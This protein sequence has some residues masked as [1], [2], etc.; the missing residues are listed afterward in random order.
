MAK[1]KKALLKDAKELYG[2][3]LDASLTLKKIKAEIANLAAAKNE[4]VLKEEVPQA[5]NETVDVTVTAK[6]ITEEVAEDEGPGEEVT[7]TEVTQSLPR[8]TQEEAAPAVAPQPQGTPPEMSRGEKYMQQ[9]INIY[10]K[11]KRE[12]NPAGDVNEAKRMINAFVSIMNNCKASNELKVTQMVFNMFIQH[13]N[14]MLAPKTALAGIGELRKTSS[15]TAHLLEVFYTVMMHGVEKRLRQT[16][17]HLD[18]K[19]ARAILKD[20]PILEFVAGI[21]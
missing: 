15:V 20:H 18:M 11:L 17:T 5:E 21:E 6:E 13:R 9:S 19:A 2:V 7:P 12:A 4:E 3:E 10:L 8:P 14:D 16:T 1:S